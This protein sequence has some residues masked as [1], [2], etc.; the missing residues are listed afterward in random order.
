MR[1]I[2][3]LELRKRL[4]NLGVEKFENIIC[5]S[6]MLALGTAGSTDMFSH[7]LASLTSTGITFLAPAYTYSAFR[8]EIFDPRESP[9][10]VGILGDQIAKMGSRSLDPAFSHSAIGNRADFL[11]SWKSGNASFGT[12][13][14]YEKLLGTSFG[15]LLVGVDLTALSLIMQ[16]E[17]QLNVPY[18]YMKTFKGK[19][20]NFETVE[21]VEIQH[22]VRSQIRIPNTD[23]TRLSKLVLEDSETVKSALPYGQMNLF[24]AQRLMK[25]VCNAYSI[26]PL[27]L[28]NADN[29]FLPPT[30]NE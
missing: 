2:Q 22:F 23:R 7:T 28:L 29:P 17:F 14:I 11:T 20:K 13:S 1:T 18:R 30:Q 8:G 4:E 25:L 3:E 15:V 9:S 12:Q 24:S 19:V 5:H 27:F 10:R 26:D 16:L 21:E 6:S